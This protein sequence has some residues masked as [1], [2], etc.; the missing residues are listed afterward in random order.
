MEDERKTNSTNF[1]DF[2][3]KISNF[4]Y[5]ITSSLFTKTKFEDNNVEEKFNEFYYPK[6][7]NN[8]IICDIMML[9]AYLGSFFFNLS[10]ELN[11]ANI[12]TIICWVVSFIFILLS[13]TIGNIKYRKVSDYLSVLFF[14][15]EGLSKGIIIYLR[16]ET[17]DKNNFI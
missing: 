7:R 9:F 13:Y 5:N 3:I 16:S 15:I 6:N 17:P 1:M 14:C 10:Y 4:N 2:I 11:E 12:S 8:R